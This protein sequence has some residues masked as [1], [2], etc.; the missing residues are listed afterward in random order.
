MAL[1]ALEARR[2]TPG[3]KVRQLADGDGL[4]LVVQP[5]D[6]KYWPRDYQFDGR[7]KTAASGVYLP[8]V[9]GSASSPR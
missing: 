9:P 3:E 7:R 6:A 4:Y 2:A 8:P 1:T 5:T